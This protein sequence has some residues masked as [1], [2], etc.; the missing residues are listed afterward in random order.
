MAWLPGSSPQSTVQPDESRNEVPPGTITAALVLCP[1][2]S[3][4]ITETVSLSFSQL[5][6]G[7]QDPQ[8]IAALGS[9][10]L[11]PAREAGSHL[12][13]SGPF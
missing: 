9:A 12:P 6:A 8:L 3:P 5:A 2:F 4:W 13:P 10:P 1:F 11:L 7:V